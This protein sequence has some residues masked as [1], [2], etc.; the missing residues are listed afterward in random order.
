MKATARP[1]FDPGKNFKARRPFVLSGVSLNY[2]DPVA[3]EGIEDRR[4]KLMYEARLIDFDDRPRDEAKAPAPAKA[5]EKKKPGKAPTA[6]PAPKASPAPTQGAPQGKAVKKYMGFGKWSV[7]D[8]A[9]NVLA[10]DI[11][12]DQ[13]DAEVAKLNKG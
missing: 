12:K 6:A 10:K 11:T 3:K 2:D 4:L 1:A 5:V 8:E 7:I 13:I 9:G